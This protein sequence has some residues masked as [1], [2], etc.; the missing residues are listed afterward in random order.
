VKP[1]IKLESHPAPLPS[2]PRQTHQTTPDT[3]QLPASGPDEK[4]L[5]KLEP[6]PPPRQTQQPTQPTQA[7]TFPQP[8][9]NPEGPLFS[10]AEN[11]TAHDQHL[12]TNL[13]TT[14]KYP[15]MTFCPGIPKHPVLRF[16]PPQNPIDFMGKLH[17]E[18]REGRVL[19]SEKL[20]CIYCRQPVARH[21]AVPQQTT[22]QRIA[23]CPFPCGA[24]GTR[25]TQRV[26]GQ[27]R[28]MKLPE[29]LH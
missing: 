15:G 2:L 7:H 20:H 8:P 17:T 4:T 16:I 6:S 1:V 19:F 22:A 13:Q 25:H 23:L 9:Q 12:Q 27:S 21:P 5:I 28:G 3:C 29:E 10:H 18:T 24:C 14:G 11:R 26:S